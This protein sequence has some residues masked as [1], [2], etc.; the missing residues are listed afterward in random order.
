MT[1]HWI[2]AH[3]TGVVWANNV[4]MKPVIRPI[5]RAGVLY[6]AL[7][8]YLLC[9]VVWLL[10]FRHLVLLRLLHSATLQISLDCCAALWVSLDCTMVVKLLV[11]FLRLLY[12]CCLLWVDK[13]STLLAMSM[14]TATAATALLLAGAYWACCAHIWGECMNCAWNVCVPNVLLPP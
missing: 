5:G 14:A 4:P 12:A 2:H 11:L 13:L 6:L 8:W 10:K 9:H 3:G 1:R 7:K